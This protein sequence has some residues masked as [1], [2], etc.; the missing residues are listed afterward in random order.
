MSTI[1]T[2]KNDQSGFVTLATAIIIFFTGLTLAI[3]IQFAGLGELQAGFQGN[4]SAQGFSIADGCLE[5]ALLRLRRDSTYTGGTL[6]IGDDYCT[7][8][9]TGSGGTRTISSTA[10]INNLINREIEVEVSLTATSTGNIVTI[11]NWEEKTN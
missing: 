8:T 2:L 1:Q 3:G 9:V 11:T 7:I 4:L 6:S 10:T 5:E